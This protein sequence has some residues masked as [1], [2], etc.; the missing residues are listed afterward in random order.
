MFEV[1]KDI[2]NKGDPTV[3][4]KTEN[5]IVLGKLRLANLINNEYYR[6]SFSIDSD[7]SVNPFSSM[8]LD[9]TQ[10]ETVTKGKTISF[11]YNYQ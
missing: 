1:G 7:I 5:D 6:L 8:T 3:M 11:L 9:M 4:T 2:E 10:L